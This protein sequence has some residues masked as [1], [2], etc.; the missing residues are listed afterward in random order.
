VNIATVMQEVSDRLDTIDS[1]ECFPYPPATI[2]TP[3]AAIVNFPSVQFDATYHRGGD[4][5][6][7]PVSIVV[8]L[9]S[10]A[11]SVWTALSAYMAGSGTR[12]IKAVLEGGT[13]TSFDSL[14]VVSA[15]V[16]VVA[17]GEINYVRANFSLDIMG[18]GA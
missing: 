9:S 15:E 1:V 7:L 4:R 14:T 2:P 6:T 5:L 13:Y 18:S 17:I 8:G 10:D 11:K 3:P 16:D 12:S